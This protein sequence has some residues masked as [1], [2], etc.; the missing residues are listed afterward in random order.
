MRHE[1]EGKAARLFPAVLLALLYVFCAP[2]AAAGQALEDRLAQTV[3][4]FD[5]ESPST[6]GQ[7]VEVAQAFRIP[8]GIEWNYTPNEG[9]ARPVHVGKASVRD[10]IRAV[11]EQ[12]P[13]YQFTVSDGVVHVS[14]KSLVNDSR[15]FLN[16]K[17][18]VF[19]VE[20]E[21]L[22][23]AKY[24][25]KISIEQLLHPSPGFGGGYGGAGLHDDFNVRK[26]T[27][28]ASGVTVREILNRLVAA[29]GN[30][31]WVV[32]IERSRMMAGEPFYAQTVS[33]TAGDTA[34]DFFW[35]F[36]PLTGTGGGG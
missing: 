21:S 24:R 22:F 7:L 1:K 32:R 26:I 9:Q 16:L 12:Q 31:L 10:V 30:A 3:E 23:G 15:N 8:M 29:Q 14:A 27:L 33:L 28:S 34:P 11:L 13:D 17:I 36:I 19:K 4:A 5:S 6:V 25:L 35:Q 20:K 2:R 18:P